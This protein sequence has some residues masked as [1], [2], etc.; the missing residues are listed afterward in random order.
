MNTA[1]KNEIQNLIGRYAPR[2]TDRFYDEG[3]S[4]SN[5]IS[6]LDEMA[7]DGDNKTVELMCHPAIVDDDLRAASSYND[8]R[9]RELALLQDR[10]ILAHLQALGIELIS[11]GQILRHSRALPRHDF[12]AERIQGK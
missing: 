10:E 8:N 5:L 9:A 7:A 3:V 2:T 6:V 12:L 1:A 11:Y 4:R